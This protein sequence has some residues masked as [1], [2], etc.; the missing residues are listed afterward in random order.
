M[1]Y[2][3]RIP[4]SYTTE[5][6]LALQPAGVL[7]LQYSTKQKNF[8]FYYNNRYSLQKLEFKKFLFF[9]LS[10]ILCQMISGECLVEIC[11]QRDLQYIGIPSG[12][13]PLAFDGIQNWRGTIVVCR[14]LKNTG[15]RAPWGFPPAS[16]GGAPAPQIFE[17][18]FLMESAPP[19]QFWADLNTLFS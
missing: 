18:Q 13:Q 12:P 15:E 19:P 2:C 8:V 7:L 4:H 1:T 10:T 14:Y 5:V 9:S 11:F 3:A 16:L 6:F 17:K